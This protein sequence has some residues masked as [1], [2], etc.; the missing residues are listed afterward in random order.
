MQFLK[1]LFWA[2][3]VGVVVAF[4]LNNM[5]MVPVR[6]W[7]SVVADVNLPLLLIVTFLLGFVPAYLSLVTVRWRARQRIAATERALADLRAA[8]ATPPATLAPGD[9]PT[10]RVVPAPAPAVTPVH[11]VDAPV[12]DNALGEHPIT[13]GTPGTITQDRS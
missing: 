5:T 7:G 8:Q 12:T 2:L 6:L 3:L 11:A 4:S 9:L 13:P 1:T 10:A